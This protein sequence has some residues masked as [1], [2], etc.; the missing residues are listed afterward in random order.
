MHGVYCISQYD[1]E[2]RQEMSE[3][4]YLIPYTYD[5]PLDFPV[6]PV[7]RLRKACILCKYNPYF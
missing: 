6:V 5:I 2:R 1:D 4:T 7:P 3:H